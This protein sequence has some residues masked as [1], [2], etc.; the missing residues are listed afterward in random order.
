MAGKNKNRTKTVSLQ[1]SF[2][3]LKYRTWAICHRSRILD[4]QRS[5]FIYRATSRK[6]DR[7]RM[8]YGEGLLMGAGRLAEAGLLTGIGRLAGTGR[9]TGTGT[10][11]DDNLLSHRFSYRRL[12]GL[13]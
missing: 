5:G 4:G 10:A 9:L 7:N 2:G 13:E 3:R 6:A 11:I 12:R 8:D 1:T